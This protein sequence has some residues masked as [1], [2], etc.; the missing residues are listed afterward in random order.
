MLHYS[1][2]IVNLDQFIEAVSPKFF[3]VSYYF[4]L[5]NE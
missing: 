3:D 4:S 5:Y 2:I 1:I